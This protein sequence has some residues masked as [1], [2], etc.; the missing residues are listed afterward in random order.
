[1]TVEEESA[2]LAKRLTAEGVIT[3]FE[4]INKTYGLNVH[5]GQRVTVHGSPGV[6][7]EDRGRYVGVSFDDHPIPVISCHPTWETVYE[8]K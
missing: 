3:A 4:Y 7:T 8:A 1:M 5:I 6:V 2:L